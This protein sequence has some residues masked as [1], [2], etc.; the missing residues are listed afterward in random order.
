LFQGTCF[1][2]GNSGSKKGE[3]VNIFKKSKGNNMKTKDKKETQP[4]EVAK[5]IRFGTVNYPVGDF[6]IQIKNAA[7][8]KNK[9]ITVIENKQVFALA[10]NLKKLRFVDDIKKE[11]GT[12]S[13]SLAFKNKRPAITN[14]K[15]VSKPGLRIYMGI[16]EIE[17][18][19]G[20]STF[21]ISSP[22][23]IISTKEAV[24]L[25][26]GGEVIAEIW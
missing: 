16:D 15:L 2:G 10:E 21:I 6:L 9:E 25:R 5:Q 4:K 19:K 23:G 13:V 26:T 8:A 18:K 3:L 11:D 1:K 14:L 7:M 20:P 17:K 12:I 24:K 22:K